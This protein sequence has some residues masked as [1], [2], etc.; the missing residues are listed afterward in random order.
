MG[1]NLSALVTEQRNP[2]TMKIDEVSTEEL[3]RLINAEDKT[4]PLAV[5]K[6]LPQ[7]MKA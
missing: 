7:I 5:E 1:L 2:N 6:E 4:V 3:C